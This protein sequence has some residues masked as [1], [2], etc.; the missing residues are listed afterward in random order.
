M[1]N[2]FKR[3]YTLELKHITCTERLEDVRQ[4]FMEYAESLPTDLS[5]QNFETELRTLPGKYGP[6]D[7]ILL[8][9]LLNEKPAGC[10]ALRKISDGICEM[11]RLFVRKEYQGLGLGKQLIAAAIKEAAAHHYGFMRL[12][13]LPTMKKAQEL[14][15]AFGFYEIEPY[16]YNPI[17]GTRYMELKL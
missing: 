12:D 9:A 2:T 4:L 8:L 16:V 7:G 6:P 15:R 17:A 11:K 1:T 14:Y 5:F 13:T 3:E 10:I